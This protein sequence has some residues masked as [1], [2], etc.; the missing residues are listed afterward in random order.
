MAVEALKPGD[1]FPHQFILL[2][3]LET[4]ITLKGTG[5]NMSILSQ[6][7]LIQAA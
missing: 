7:V 1:A 3:S 5:A 4:P 2:R 6:Y